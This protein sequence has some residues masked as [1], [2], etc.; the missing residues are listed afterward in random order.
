MSETPQTVRAAVIQAA[1]PAFDLPGAL[2]RVEALAT[3][4]A[5]RGAKLVVFPEAFIGGYPKGHDFGARVGSRTDEGRA[6]FA[7]Y[8]GGAM[9]V[10]GPELTQLTELARTLDVVLVVG[11]IEVDGGTLYCTTVIIDDDG[12]FLGKHRKVMPTG[13]ERLIW[14]FG[15]GSTLPVVDS[16]VG[17]VGSAICWENYMPLLRMSLYQQG[18]QF[19]CASTVDDRDSWLYSMRHIA[20]EGRCFVL[21]SCQFAQRKDY[22]DDYECI[23][24]NDP[25]TIMIRG[26]SC[27]V[28]PFGRL[29]AE[30]VY[31][32]EAVLV[33][34]LDPSLIIQGKYDLDVTGHYGRPDIFSL[35][36][37]RRPKS[38][39]NLSE[40]VP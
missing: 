11:L 20:V 30:P 17:R 39:V 14:G 23:Q 28:D 25:E 12:R 26:G 2:A 31:N 22:P 1:A 27:I 7:R 8:Y 3:Q 33:A 19:Y 32:R 16:A 36:V 29:L 34:D 24:G 35:H 10:P 40:N 5:D 6:M 38:A 4:A 9:P 21:S 15:D 13:T 37:D 18:I